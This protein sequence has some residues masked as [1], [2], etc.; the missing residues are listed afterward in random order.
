MKVVLARKLNKRLIEL[1]E[2]TTGETVGLL[3]K[4]GTYSYHSWLGFIHRNKATR[5]GK[6]VKLKIDRIVLETSGDTFNTCVVDTSILGS[7]SSN[8]I[9]DPTPAPAGITTFGI[10]IPRARR[11]A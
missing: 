11:E 10:P 2:C 8:P 4:D 3:R 6:P 7:A 9:A 1:R 5:L